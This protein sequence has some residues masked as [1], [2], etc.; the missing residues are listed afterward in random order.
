MIYDLVTKFC[1][2]VVQRM[3]LDCCFQQWFIQPKVW[4]RKKGKQD[5]DSEADI[6][7]SEVS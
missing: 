3:Q 7:I 4:F 2:V 5:D 1:A 6:Q